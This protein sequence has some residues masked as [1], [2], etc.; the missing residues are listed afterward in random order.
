MD[1]P[2]DAMNKI[3]LHDCPLCDQFRFYSECP[4]DECLYYTTKCDVGCILLGSSVPNNSTYGTLSKQLSIAEILFYKGDSIPR[5][6]VRSLSLL[7]KEGTFRLRSIVILH[8]YFEW[9]RQNRHDEINKLKAIMRR[10]NFRSRF[11]LELLNKYPFSVKFFSVT[12]TILLYMSLSA[13]YKEF[14]KVCK[15]PVTIELA[16]LMEISTTDLSKLKSIRKKLT[17]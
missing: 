3:D 17:K 8:Y 10:Q 9:L 5:A 6:T 1:A 14:K 7:K 16:D 15:I 12:P 4:L 2:D 13:N 11:L